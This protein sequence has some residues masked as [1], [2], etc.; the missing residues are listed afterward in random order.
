MRPLLAFGA[1]RIKSGKAPLFSSHMWDGSAVDMPE[2]MRIADELIDFSNKS[3]RF[4]F[5]GSFLHLFFINC[6]F[7]IFAKDYKIA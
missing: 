1:E 3:S 5:L 4:F 7:R 2:N 6:F